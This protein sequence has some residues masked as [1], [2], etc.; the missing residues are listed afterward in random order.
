MTDGKIPTDMPAE[1]L[2]KLFDSFTLPEE[3]PKLVVDERWL[4]ADAEMPEP[5]GEGFGSIEYAWSD[6]AGSNDYLTK[7]KKTRKLNDLC[8]GLKAGPYSKEWGEK[9]TKEKVNL[10]Q[11]HQKYLAAKRARAAKK[12]AAA[13]KTETAEAE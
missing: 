13:T 1:M 2:G 12:A 4:P 8:V 11:K 6:R 7:Y 5:E 9:W 3:G 10:R